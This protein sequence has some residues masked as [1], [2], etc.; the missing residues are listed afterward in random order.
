[1][2]VWFVRWLGF[3]AVGRALADRRGRP[4]LDIGLGFA[5]LR[6]RRV[7]IIQ[8]LAALGLGITAIAVLIALELPVEGLIAAL[9]NLP[10]IGLD[11]LVD[12]LEILAGPLVIGSLFLIR[13]APAEIAASLREERGA[14]AVGNRLRRP[15]A[16]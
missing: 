1:M 12:G 14:T 15:T 5:L 6:D 13:L 8:K 2:L 11:F 9:L 7:P 4:R 3:R 10:G 16:R